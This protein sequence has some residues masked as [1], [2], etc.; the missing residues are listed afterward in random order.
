M[1]DRVQY[2]D[3]TPDSGLDASAREEQP[4]RHSLLGD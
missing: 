3:D 4:W 1:C 2:E